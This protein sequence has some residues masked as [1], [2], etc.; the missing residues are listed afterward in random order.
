MSPVD[1]LLV[2][3]H[4]DGKV[5]VW[6]WHARKPVISWQEHEGEVRSVAFSSDAKRVASGGEDNTV[7]VWCPDSPKSLTC[8][9]VG[10]YS[11]SYE[12]VWSVTFAENDRTIVAG[13][14]DRTLRLWDWAK[15]GKVEELHGHS[16][17]IRYVAV[18]P[19]EALLASAGRDGTIK[20]WDLTTRSLI[21][22]LKGHSGIVQA[23]AFSPTEASVLA[24]ASQDRTVMVWK[25]IKRSNRRSLSCDR[26]L[27]AVAFLPEEQ[28]LLGYP[29]LTFDFPRPAWQNRFIVWDLAAQDP[30]PVAVSAQVA[31]TSLDL[32]KHG[33]LAAAGEH[34]DVQIFE[35]VRPKRP[36]MP[37]FTPRTL[38]PGH[39]SGTTSAV[40]FS[41]DGR[42]LAVGTTEGELFV[43]PLDSIGSCRRLTGHEGIQVLSLSWSPEGALAA[44]GNDGSIRLW[45][46]GSN[47]LSLARPTN[48]EPV[49]VVAF[50]ADGELLASGGGDGII[51]LWS[52]GST[53]PTRHIAGHSTSVRHLAFAEE[54]RTL[55][56]VSGDCTARIWDIECGTCRFVF[57]KHHAAF[58]HVAYD[59]TSRTIAAAARDGTVQLWQAASDEEVKSTPW[60]P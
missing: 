45:N 5:V 49:M 10:E 33:V 37:F 43:L 18:S 55:V 44:G 3:G 52:R 32:S 19:H 50:S 47:A 4:Y 31:V 15:Q 39:C 38:L 40:A 13:G 14:V 60:F 54:G 9:K 7:R 28:L 8:L 27:G 21:G 1:D 48:R 56:S 30:Q 58:S 23:V 53:K 42:E 2:T 29:K 41:A 25:D 57:P 26:G 59:P 16:D 35:A 17:E 34:G 6:N 22:D 46:V 36:G 11:S 12:G 51:R 24:S 20:L